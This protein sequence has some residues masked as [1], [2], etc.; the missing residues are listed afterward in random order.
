MAKIKIQCGNC[1]KPFEITRQKDDD[2]PHLY[3]FD[4]PHCGLPQ[5]IMVK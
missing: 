1:G 3:R 2:V 5:F 4:C